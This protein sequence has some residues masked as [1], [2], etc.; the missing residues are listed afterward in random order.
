M[1]KQLGMLHMLNIIIRDWDN[2]ITPEDFTST[3]LKHRSNLIDYC[4][5]YEE[6]SF[7]QKLKEA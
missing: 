7:K 2:S 3:L 6:A 4:E 1:D 5:A